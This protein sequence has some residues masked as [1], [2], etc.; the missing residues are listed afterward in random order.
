MGEAG[1]I[2]SHINTKMFSIGFP[3]ML[4]GTCDA[5]WSSRKVSKGTNLTSSSCI[6][7]MVGLAEDFQCRLRRGS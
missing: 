6:V 1:R 2:T 5:V 3:R 7:R 4:C